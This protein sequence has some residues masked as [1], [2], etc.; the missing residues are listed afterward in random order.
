MMMAGNLRMTRV[1]CNIFAHPELAAR[2]PADDASIPFEKRQ[3]QPEARVEVWDKSAFLVHWDCTD[4][5]VFRVHY[6][7][8]R[9]GVPGIS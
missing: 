5:S 3:V 1:D 6:P 9:P 7:K 4:F 2:S 8:G